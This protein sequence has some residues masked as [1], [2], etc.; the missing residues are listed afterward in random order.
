MKERI[1]H[2]SHSHIV[3][4][5]QQLIE[6]QHIFEVRG[7]HHHTAHGTHHYQSQADEHHVVDG[8]R[9]TLIANKELVSAG[10]PFAI[11]CSML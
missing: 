3:N 9:H 7:E 8:S 11:S 5:R 10:Q 6:G 1:S 4:N 2:N